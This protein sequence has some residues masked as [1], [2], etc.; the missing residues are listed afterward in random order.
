MMSARLSKL[1][2]REFGGDWSK[3][4]LT[5]AGVETMLLTR[6]RHDAVSA[7]VLSNLGQR[8]RNLAGA[9]DEEPRHRA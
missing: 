6:R 1:A 3:T 9:F 2:A 5:V 7:H 8:P 4:G